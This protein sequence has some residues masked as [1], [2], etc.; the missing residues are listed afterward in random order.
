MLNDMEKNEMRM[1]DEAVTGD[2]MIDEYAEAS[3]YSKM[4]MPWWVRK[5]PAVLISVALH[6]ILLV[7]A[8]Y[9]E[10]S[11]GIE[12][13]PDFEMLVKQ[14]FRRQQFDETLPLDIKKKP[15]LP[16][17]RVSEIPYRPL[18]EEIEITQDIPRGTSFE[19]VSNKNLNSNSV[20]DAFGIGCGASGAY[21]LRTGHGG[22]L[23]GGSIGTEDSVVAA[24]RWLQYHQDQ[25]GRWD[26]DG[27]SKNCKKGTC[28]GAA[29]APY[30]DVGASALALLA[31]LGNGHTHQVGEFK[32]TVRKG[33][34]FLKTQQS[35]D[36]RIGPC[37][38]ESWFYNH[39][40]ALM[41]I[42]EAYAMTKDDKMK[43]MA[44]N[45]LRYGLNAQNPGYGWKYE[46][47]GGKSDTSVTGWMVLALKAAKTGGLEV[48]K[49]AF[50]DA[51]KWFDRVTAANGRCG[52][53]KPGDPGSIL[54]GRTKN[55]ERQE[56]MTAVSLI[57]R[58]FTGQK[59]SDPE[60][61][62]GAELIMQKLPTYDAP[63]HLKVN[64]YYW[65]NG[66]YAMFQIGGEQWKKWNE[67]MKTALLK[68][69]RRDGCAHGSWDAVCE[70]A[71]VGGRV[72]CT[73]INAL[74]LEIYYRFARI[75]NGEKP[76]TNAAGW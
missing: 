18:E 9:I 70:W 32:K 26:I 44:E 65:Y 36:G 29:Q 72:Y 12:N 60:I 71:V 45:A 64:Y 22:L 28:D 53:E 55:F 1:D 75:N 5:S 24:L 49:Q 25:D 23:P 54:R 3:S 8:A 39:A 38:G 7:I 52:Y 2:E 37:E 6:A 14:D 10:A 20:V 66:T 46:P 58:I 11:S 27:F 48:P 50:E 43:Q 76:G 42:S 61:K 19:N 62:K 68:S 41:A 33:L 40:I 21:G 47:R 57:C 30:F 31:Y 56:T 34:R 17:E 16:Y 73:A 69:Q 67:A 15:N 63:N 13:K 74:S 4:G 35:S 51:R 59:R